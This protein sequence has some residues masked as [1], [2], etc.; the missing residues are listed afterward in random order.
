MNIQEIINDF[1]KELEVPI[2]ETKDIEEYMFQKGKKKMLQE[3]IV[4]LNN[5]K[6]KNE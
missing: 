4:Y 2:P 6:N 3:V 1:L 5:I